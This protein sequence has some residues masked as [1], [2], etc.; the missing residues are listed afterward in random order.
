ML[1]VLVPGSLE[2]QEGATQL[3]QQMEAGTAQRVITGTKIQILTLASDNLGAN[4]GHGTAR[5]SPPQAKLANKDK[6]R[7]ESAELGLTHVRGW[8]LLTLCAY[9]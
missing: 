5:L 6:F 4:P 7:A 2:L 8:H 9:V 1:I 3:N